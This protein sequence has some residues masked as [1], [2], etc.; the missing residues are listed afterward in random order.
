LLY[1]AAMERCYS[2][3]W[4]SLLYY[5]AMEKCYSDKWQSISDLLKR[6]DSKAFQ[7][8]FANVACKSYGIVIARL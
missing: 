6:A 4:G 2:D 8:D 5:A 1:F 3:K 7:T